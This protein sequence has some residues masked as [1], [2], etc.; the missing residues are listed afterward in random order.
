[1][2]Q[3]VLWLFVREKV[4]HF[5]LLQYFNSWNYVLFFISRFETRAKRKTGVAKFGTTKIPCRLS[6]SGLGRYTVAALDLR[7]NINFSCI[8][9][10]LKRLC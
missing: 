6:H 10:G 1:M 2:H 4:C 3:S 5:T 9:L 8:K 7:E